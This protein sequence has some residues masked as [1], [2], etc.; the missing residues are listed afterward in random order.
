MRDF[1]NKK[2]IPSVMLVVN[3]KAII[4]IKNGMMVVMPFTIIGSVFLLLA[5]LPIKPLAEAINNAGLTPFLNQAFNASFGIM[6]F[7]AVM[8]IASSYVKE[9]GFDGQ[10]AGM[11]ALSG[12]VLLMLPEV[13]T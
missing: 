8:G 5:N 7:F 12:F 11:I 13:M 2:L 9:S 1:V 10:P 4:S 3:T 6:A